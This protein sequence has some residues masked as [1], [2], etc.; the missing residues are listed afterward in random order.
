MIE[1]EVVNRFLNMITTEYDGNLARQFQN[2]YILR[3]KEIERLQ[4][5]NKQ[6]KS[7][8][9]E[10]EDY[11]KLGMCEPAYIKGDMFWQNACEEVLDKIQELKEKY[12]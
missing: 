12:K 11:L 4:Q 2:Q 5:E 7:I 9:T 10:L 3:Y 6:L 8:L 1:E